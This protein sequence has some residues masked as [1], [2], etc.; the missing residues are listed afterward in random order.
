M[1]AY[2]QYYYQF[3]VNLGCH[4]IPTVANKNIYG[5][6]LRNTDNHQLESFDM[7]AKDSEVCQRLQHENL[8]LGH[9]DGVDFVHIY[10][11]TTCH[12]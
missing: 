12:L 5:Y 8:S 7:L 2:N 9:R 4:A 10:I 3:A 6:I 11:Y 1:I